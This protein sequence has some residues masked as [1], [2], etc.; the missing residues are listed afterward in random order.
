M[1]PLFIRGSTGFRGR[2]EW[3]VSGIFVCKLSFQLASSHPVSSIASCTKRASPP[4]SC[5]PSASFDS[6]L[7]TKCDAA[8]SSPGL[9]DASSD[10][11]AVLNYSKMPLDW[12]SVHD[13][14]APAGSLK[15]STRT[16]I[17]S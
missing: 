3:K 12:A 10:A 13:P 7:R 2:L 17:I 14:S 9:Q 11:K 5:S 15:D 4:R 1:D 8:A 6:T 16:Q